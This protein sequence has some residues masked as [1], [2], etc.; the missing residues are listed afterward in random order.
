[1]GA[2][3]DWKDKQFGVKVNGPDGLGVQA[4]A[5]VG[6]GVGGGGVGGGFPLDS[7]C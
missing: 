5:S 3:D 2:V 4:G 6:V 1:M 7:S